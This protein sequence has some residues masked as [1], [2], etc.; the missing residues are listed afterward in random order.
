MKKTSLLL[1]MCFFVGLSTS[2]AFPGKEK[3][4][5]KAKKE[6]RPLTLAQQIM[7]YVQYPTFAAQRNW[8]GV[9]RLSYT[10]NERNQLNVLEIAC[11]NE[12]LKE[13]VKA[14]IDGKIV[15][16]PTNDHTTVRYLKLR[17]N[18]Y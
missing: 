15:A 6:D 18:L 16:D 3:L 8:E 7:H 2:H 11:P 17:F 9:V 4:Y 1:A 12:Q 10:I 13:Y 5:K 14:Q